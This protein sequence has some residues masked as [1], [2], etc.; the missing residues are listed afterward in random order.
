MA[1]VLASATGIG[2]FVVTQVREILQRRLIVMTEGLIL[3]ETQ[4][5]QCFCA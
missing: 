3:A 4:L 2:G 1:G 5:V